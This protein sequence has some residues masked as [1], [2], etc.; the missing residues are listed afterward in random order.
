M[1][2][3]TS[4]IARPARGLS[5]RL[6]A[7]AVYF[8]LLGALPAHPYKLV[9]AAGDYAL[10]FLHQTKRHSLHMKRFA[11]RPSGERPDGAARRQWQ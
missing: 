2:V 5:S 7:I 1:L 6:L 8:A 10:F 4:G 9:P 11:Q 3:S